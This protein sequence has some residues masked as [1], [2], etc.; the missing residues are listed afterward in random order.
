MDAP[1]TQGDTALEALAHLA[2]NMSGMGLEQRFPGLAERWVLRAV[3]AYVAAG[4][5]SD[6]GGGARRGRSPVRLLLD[7]G[8]VRAAR[9]LA[10]AA[11]VSVVDMEPSPCLPGAR[12]LGARRLAEWDA[13]RAAQ[14]ERFA[15]TDALLAAAATGGAAAEAAAAS[16]P[17]GLWGLLGGCGAAA[18]R[19]GRSLARA[20]RERHPAA[21]AWLAAWEA[22]MLVAWAMAGH[23][24][25]GAAA[26][27]RELGD[28][29]LRRIGEMAAAAAR[30]G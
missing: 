25:L 4:A 11:G 27:P 28:D 9:W 1:S 14:R 8:M 10:E 26:S 3:Q 7:A 2:C 5:S 20:A 23:P 29:L 21:A 24:R 12:R 6:G 22:R 19:H 16:E 15:R 13:L 30:S 17:G 18:D